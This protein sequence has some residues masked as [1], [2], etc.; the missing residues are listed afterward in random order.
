MAPEIPMGSLWAYDASVLNQIGCVYTAH[1]FEFDYVGVIF[2]QDLVYVPESASWKGD[3]TKSYDSVVK[4]SG[5]RFTQMV[6]NTYRVL[7]TR[8]MKGC[9]VTSMDKN[10]EHFFRS[11]MK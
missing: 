4:R 10:T 6:Q 1:G 5:T 8:G 9:Y 11:R 7:L 3:N 2:G